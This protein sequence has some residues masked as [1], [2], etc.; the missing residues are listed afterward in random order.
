MATK[1]AWPVRAGDNESITFVW[2]GTVIVG[3]TYRCEIRPEAGDTGTALATAT[4]AVAQVS[5]NVEVTVSLSGVQTRALEDLKV[6]VYDLE[7]NAG[8]VI[9]TLFEGPVQITR[10]VTV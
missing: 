8:G 10:D 1:V 7:E 2:P 4:T 6:P 5:T 3:A 9:S